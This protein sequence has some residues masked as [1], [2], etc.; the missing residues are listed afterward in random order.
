ML[1]HFVADK[2]Q[3]TLLAVGSVDEIAKREYN[4]YID[5]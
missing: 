4:R 5:S 1:M 2:Q 3:K